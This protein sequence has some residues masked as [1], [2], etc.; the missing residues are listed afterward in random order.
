MSKRHPFRFGVINEQMKAPSAWFDHVRRV[1]ALGYATLLL[2][3]HF[4]PDF[5]GDQYAPLVAL[6]AAASVTTTL[7]L[8]TMVID[9]DY[10]H[11]VMLA[12]EAATLD[13]LSGGRFELGIG[14]G[15]LRTEYEQAGLPFDRA[16]MR[17]DRLEESIRV[18]KGIWAE[19]PTTFAGQHYQVTGI[20]GVP[21]PL[22]RPH[23]PLLIG[24]GKE[25]MLKLAGREADIVGILT[26]DVS[27]GTLISDIRE[28]M[29]AAVHQKIDWIRQGAGH[30]FD[31]IELSLIPTIIFTDDR[32]SHIESLIRQ[33]G[34]D[35]TVEA[36]LQMPSM[37]IGSIEEIAQ[38]LQARRESYGFSYYVVADDQ[39]DSFAPVI[40]WLRVSNA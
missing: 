9:N 28:R 6:M 20:N 13:C 19:A 8:G 29:A 39:M 31:Q 22:Q 14:A 27:S 3:D 33:Q 36:V 21:K 35:I 34:W 24:G 4:V 23:P 16:G 15:W 5:F 17:I 37:L 10:R 30:R 12:K 18:M 38:D 2:R 11:P 1:E 25:R 40:E 32:C 7:R 26:S